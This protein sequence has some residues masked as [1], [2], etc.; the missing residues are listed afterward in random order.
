MDLL[1]TGVKVR[2][3]VNLADRTGF[4]DPLLIGRNML[5]EGN[6]GVD[7]RQIFAAKRAC[8]SGKYITQKSKPSWC[9]PL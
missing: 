4:N 1:V 6:I 7:S 5:S 3:E 8:P 2:G 9:C